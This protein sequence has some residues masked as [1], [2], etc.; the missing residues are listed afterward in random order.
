[1]ARTIKQF[2]ARI[3]RQRKLKFGSTMASQLRTIIGERYG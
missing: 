3:A 1:V 2:S